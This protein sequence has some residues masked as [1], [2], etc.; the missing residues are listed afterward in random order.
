MASTSLLVHSSGAKANALEFVGVTIA[1]IIPLVP[2]LILGLVCGRRD[3]QPDERRSPTWIPLM[4]AMSPG[5]LEALVVHFGTPGYSLSYLPGLLLLFILPMRRL[6]ST[7]PIAMTAL[8]MVAVACAYQAE[9]YVFA[10]TVMPARVAQASRV[11]ADGAYGAPYKETFHALRDLD[12]DQLRYRAIRQD[13]DPTRDVLVYV[14]GDGNYRYRI[15]GYQ[16][17]EFTLHLVLNG[18]DIDQARRGRHTTHLGPEISVPPG[19]RAVL[20]IDALRPE[21]IQLMDEG[22]LESVP[23]STGPVVYALKPGNTAFGIRFVS[24]PLPPI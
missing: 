20:V 13:F 4:L 9:R 11:W 2:L 1:T 6:P 3:S 12:A 23:L 15:A 22:Q 21:L 7:G 10:P 24:G 16:L 17:P 5:L 18:T 8:I 19:G 14:T